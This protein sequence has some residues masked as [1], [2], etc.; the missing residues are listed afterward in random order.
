MTDAT[1]DAPT[2]AR[3]ARRRGAAAAAAPNA[4]FPPA[5]P[6]GNGARCGAIAAP[7]DAPTDAA[8]DAAI[9]APGVIARLEE[10][11]R[12]LLALPHTGPSPRLRTSAWDVL[13]NAVEGY[14]WEGARLR[15]AMP[16]AARVTRMDEA[17]GWLALI[18]QERYV[19]RRI[20]GA[21]A[22]VHP[23]TGRHLYPWRRLG[24]AVG[25][26]HKAVQRWHGQG[27]ALIVAAINATCLR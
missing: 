19:L 14:G 2:G 1:T 9:D 3:P 7:T 6:E 16:G 8:P 23:L 11:G 15:P 22:L 12:T 27:I 26:D 25:A 20:V 21:R 17:F 13:Q 4:P 5:K 24:A 10:A 18:P